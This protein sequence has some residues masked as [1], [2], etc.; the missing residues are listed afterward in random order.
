MAGTDVF[1]RLLL[2]CSNLFFSAAA[3]AQL[4]GDDSAFYSAAVSAACREY[5]LSIGDQSGLYNG[6]LYPGYTFSFTG[7]SPLFNTG[8]PDTG[9]VRY[10][11]LLYTGVL[12]Y[13]D[14]LS[15]IV[16]TD[17]NGY[18]VQLDNQKLA[19]FSIGSHHFIQ[20]KNNQGTVPGFYELLY[21]GGIRVLKQVIKKMSDQ[22]SPGGTAEK[23]ITATA[24]FYIQKGSVLYPVENK[25]DL[26]KVLSDRKKDILRFIKKN[27]LKFRGNGENTLPVIAAYYD[28]IRK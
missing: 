13:Y 26:A 4:H 6:M 15:Q 1:F 27:K 25:N 17:D 22:V 10:D 23:L 5:Q 3:A 24:R 8:I 19:E 7:E 20:V 2:V 16:F 14:D 21:S 12:V 9:F 11:G 28:Q 18:K